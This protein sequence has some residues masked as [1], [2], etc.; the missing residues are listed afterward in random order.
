MIP[1][2]RSR[3]SPVDRFDERRNELAE[4]A[5]LTLGEL[6]YARTSLRDI[7]KHSPYS[8]GVLH[9]YFADKLELVSYSVTY[10][11]ERCVHR[12]DDVVQRSQSA[13]ELLE[14]F[15]DKL[16]ETILDEA[17][18]HRLWYDLRVESMFDERLRDTVLRIDQAL[19]DMIWRIVTR[20]AELADREV[21]MDPTSAYAVFDGLF[22]AALL[23]HVT[24]DPTALPTL[25]GQVH[26]L[27]PRTLG[28]LPHEAA[29]EKAAREKTVDAVR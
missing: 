17:P 18:M 27:L 13:Q 7:A 25:V 9:Y 23:K 10:Y 24:G 16:A 26:Q 15:A 8:H 14:G 20:Y 3:R 29:R 22:Q 1:S 12:Y 5:L 19:E 4:S 2:T 6:G 21:T 28:P 11:K